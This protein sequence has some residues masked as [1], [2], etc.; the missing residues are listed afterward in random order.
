MEPDILDT[1]RIGLIQTDVDYEA[2]WSGVSNMTSAE[3]GKSWA[4]IKR[5]FRS[6]FDGD[7]A[8]QIVL[9]P[10]LAVPRDR[11]PDLKRFA[12]SLNAIVIAGMDYRI[13]RVKKIVINEAVVI[14]PN[15]PGGTKK[16][17]KIAT[18]YVRKTFPSAAERAAVSA[19]GYKFLGDP[20]CIQFYSDSFGSFGIAICY[21]LMDLERAFLYRGFVQHLFVLAYNRDIT[22]FYHL[23]E[24]LSRSMFVSVVICNTG[25]FGG[26]VAVAPYYHPWKRTVYRHEGAG[27]PTAQIIEIPAKSIK[28]AQMEG[29]IKVGGDDSRLKGLPPGFSSRGSL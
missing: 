4:Y 6:F 22:S 19:A 9:I 26:S 12:R 28:L 11:I 8:P 1:V 14:I 16:S 27:L 29:A 21:D 23:A 24:A 18:R 25:H 20:Q 10:E 5:G 13:N 7:L 17:F 3:A 15:N 2:A